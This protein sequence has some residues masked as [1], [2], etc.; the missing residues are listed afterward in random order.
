MTLSQTAVRYGIN[1]D[2]TPEIIENLKRVAG[3]LEEIR[4]LVNMPIV[5]SSGYRS[6]ALNRAV[7]GARNSAHVLG[8]AADI[9]AAR[10][11]PKRLAQIIADSPIRFDQ[12]IMEFGRWVHVGLATG[13]AQP[14]REILTA[15]TVNGRTQYVKGIE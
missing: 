10:L 7:G 9:N 2:P 1:N 13:L 14:R 12:L 3:V 8:L 15:K 5:V 11:D 4:S 6:P